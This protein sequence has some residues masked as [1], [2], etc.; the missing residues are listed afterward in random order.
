MRHL[1]A[2]CVIHRLLPDTLC[3]FESA[4]P[5]L[6]LELLGELLSTPPSRG[7]RWLTDTCSMKEVPYFLKYHHSNIWKRNTEGQFRGHENQR[8]HSSSSSVRKKGFLFQ[9]VLL[10]V[11]TVT[12]SH[13]KCFCQPI[14]SQIKQDVLRQSPASTEQKARRQLKTAA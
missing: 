8:G 9:Q 10:P 12:S 4:S 7:R 2:L 6:V 13:F 1:K 11:N 3:R 5:L 14:R